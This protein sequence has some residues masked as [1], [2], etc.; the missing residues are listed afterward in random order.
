MLIESKIFIVIGCFFFST[1]IILSA[2]GFHGPDQI[3]APRDRISWSWAVEMQI[4]HSLGLILIGFLANFLKVSWVIRAAGILMILGILIFSFLIYANA[5][6]LIEEISN[7]VPV[8]GFMFITSWLL[9]AIGVIKVKS[10]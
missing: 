8:G 9:L 10:I 7:I 4:Y 3:L 2:F 5:V 6:G 1:A